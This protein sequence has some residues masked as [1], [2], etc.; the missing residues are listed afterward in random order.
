MLLDLHF[1]ERVRVFT[2]LALASLLLLAFGLPYRWAEGLVWI[3]SPL[4]IL[5]KLS[6]VVLISLH[7]QLHVTVLDDGHSFHALIALHASFELTGIE[8]VDGL[9]LPLILDAD[10]LVLLLSGRGFVIWSYRF[11]YFFKI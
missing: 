11:D 2:F 7:P 1:S 3:L 6:I 10:V 9:L 8:R 4:H 5:H